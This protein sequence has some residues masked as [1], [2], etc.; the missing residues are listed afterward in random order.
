MSVMMGMRLTVDPERFMQ[1]MREEAERANAISERGKQMGAVHHMFLAGDGEVM[2]ADEW[3][4][5]ESFLAFFDAA[6]EDIGVLMQ[7][8]GVSNQPEPRF[9]KPLETSDRF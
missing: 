6:S 4:S 3:D 7:K 8:A 5:K 1:V 2:V 9:W